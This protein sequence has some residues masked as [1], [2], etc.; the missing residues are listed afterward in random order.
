MSIFI[1]YEKESDTKARVTLQHYEPA[2]LPPE[3]LAIGELVDSIPHPN[4]QPGQSPVLYFNPTDKTFSYE[5]VDT[6]PTPEEQL[7]A[8]QDQL[9]TADQKYKE[10][11]L[12]TAALADVRNAKMVQLDEACNNTIVA[13]FDATVNGTSYKF[14]CS[15]AAQANFQGTDTLFKD[16]AITQAEWTVINTNTGK[17]ERINI[18]Q[19]T[20]NTL[21]LQVFQHINSNISK[22]RNTLQPQVEEATTNA[23]VDKINW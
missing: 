14:S 6:P 2:S 18:D 22:L 5:Y 12:T 23:D 4:P 7:K 20:F 9:K 17:T 15:L 13:G 3:I 8:L 16:G 1:Q 11:D 21:K 10:L 19:T